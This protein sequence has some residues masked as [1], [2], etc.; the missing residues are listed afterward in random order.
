MKLFHRH[1][2]L[3]YKE[4]TPESHIEGS[5]KLAL[6]MKDT[7]DVVQDV[8]VYRNVTESPRHSDIGFRISFKS[9]EDLEVYGPHPEHAK[10]KEFDAP[11]FGKA[12]VIDYWD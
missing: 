1:L 5:I 12:S 9:A 3:T 11:Y 4:G 8:K 2:F 7:I 6:S 10:L